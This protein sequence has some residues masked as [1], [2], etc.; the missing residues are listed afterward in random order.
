MLQE[1]DL[2]YKLNHLP[3][4]LKKVNIKDLRKNLDKAY[5]GPSYVLQPFIWHGITYISMTDRIPEWIVV[6][7]YKQA[8]DVQDICYFYDHSH[9]FINY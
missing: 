6:G 9:R 8:E 2:A 7:K 5:I 4:Y 3:K 1:E